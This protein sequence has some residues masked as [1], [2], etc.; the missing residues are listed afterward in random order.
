MNRLSCVLLV[1]LVTLSA[2]STLRRSSSSG[3]SDSQGTKTAEAVRSETGGVDISADEMDAV[4]RKR[5]VRQL[6]SRLE[7]RR[8]REQYSK[9]LPWLESDAEKI[10]F[11]SINSIESR[12]AW[13][14]SKNIWRRS[15]SATSDSKEVIDAGDIA[16]GMPMDHVR[17][18]WGEP[19]NVEVSGNPLYHNER[20]KYVKFISSA[21]GYRQEKRFVYFEGGRVVG[22]E[23]E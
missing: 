17:K 9:I 5:R 6:E 2:C 8:E 12:Q 4:E 7:S 1:S 18:S 20:W 16:V 21:N 23:T 13:I 10:E 14:N 15:Q 19:Q 22:W 3:Y 11:L